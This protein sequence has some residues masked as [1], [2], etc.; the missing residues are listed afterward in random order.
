MLIKL[1]VFDIEI[2]LKHLTGLIL[3]FNQ[4]LVGF[5]LKAKS[6]L[7]HA[8]SSNSDQS[9]V[10]E[11]FQSRRFISTSP[12]INCIGLF[13]TVS[14]QMNIAFLTLLKFLVRN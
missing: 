14:R 13:T 12:E 11:L 7:S 2:I 8:T 6:D 3:N 9:D 1:Q 5:K 10:S 4:L